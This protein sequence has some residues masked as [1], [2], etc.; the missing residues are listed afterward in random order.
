[1]VSLPYGRQVRRRA[2]VIL[3]PHHRRAVDL[4]RREKRLGNPPAPWHFRADAAKRMH[5]YDGVPPDRRRRALGAAGAAGA[6]E[7]AAHRLSAAPVA[8]E[9]KAMKAVLFEKHGG[10]EVLRL[11][12]VPDP[13]AGPGEV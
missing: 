6:C 4:H 2:A 10:P 8:E 12:D 3:R 11:G 7:R 5:A 9:K 13:V 1:M